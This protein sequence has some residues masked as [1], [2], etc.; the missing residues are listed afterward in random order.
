MSYQ[1]TAESFLKDVASH[2]LVVLR[3]D[4]LYRHMRFNR[5]GNSCMHFDLI[6]VPGK[7]IY[8]GDMGTYVFQRL[9]DMFEFFRT[10]RSGAELRINTGY[11]AE[12]LIA[13][14]CHGKHANGAKEFSEEKFQQRVLEWI[15][16]THRLDDDGKDELRANVR[17]RVFDAADGDRTGIRA[18]DAIHNF[19]HNGF[20]FEDFWEVD[21]TEWTT[22]FVWCCYALAWG[23][24]RY[25]EATRKGGA[26]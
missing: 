12:K 26:V 14:D 21:C 22:P 3:D 23:I 16:E 19:E 20:R 6:T 8:T 4:G 18:M 17:D 24:A 15:D 13:S 1:V 5:P 11:W 25:D 9:N 2:Q 7:L 10:D